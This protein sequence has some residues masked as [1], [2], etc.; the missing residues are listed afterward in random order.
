MNTEN[1]EDKCN[2]AIFC[3]L[4]DIELLPDLKNLRSTVQRR[5]K[6]K[7]FLNVNSN[8][9]KGSNEV[10]ARFFEHVNKHFRKRNM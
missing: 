3:L 2:R 9:A 6:Q 1:Q 4:L 7:S 8:T 5:P 10:I